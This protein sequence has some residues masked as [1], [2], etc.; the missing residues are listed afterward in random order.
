MTQLW[1]LIMLC[2]MFGVWL[3]FSHLIR[4]TKI[5]KGLPYKVFSKYAWLSESRAPWCHLYVEWC[6]RICYFLLILDNENFLTFVQLDLKVRQWAS[7]KK[8]AYLNWWNFYRDISIAGTSLCD[9]CLSRSRVHEFNIFKVTVRTYMMISM[10]ANQKTTKKCC[11]WWPII[12][13]NV[14]F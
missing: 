12:R 11:R 2:F 5:Y 14:T 13:P 8:P 3:S 4:S 6:V 7:N 1:G 9:D 10:W